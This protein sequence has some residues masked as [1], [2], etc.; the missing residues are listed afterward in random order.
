MLEKFIFIDSTRQ[1]NE[2]AS[3]GLMQIRTSSNLF[4]KLLRRQTPN[5]RNYNVIELT[6]IAAGTKESCLVNKNCENVKL[7]V[8]FKRK[9]NL[10]RPGTS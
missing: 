4:V 8:V 10:R 7:F 2:S 6:C 9:K 1:A 5:F 3:Y